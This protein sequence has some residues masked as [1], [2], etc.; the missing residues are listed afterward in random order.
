MKKCNSCGNVSND[1]VKFCAHCGSSSFSQLSENS[2]GQPQ[3]FQTPPPPYGSQPHDTTPPAYNNPPSYNNPPAY[4]NPPV[5]NPP[6]NSVN[7]AE[8]G[9]ENVI[10]GL[11]GALLFSLIGVVLYVVIYQ[12]N[13]IA[14]ICGL[15]MF[16]LASFG[17]GVFSKSK[18]KGSIPGL[19]ISIIVTIV[20]I[21]V[22]EYF[23]LAL[24]IYKVYS[25]FGVTIFDAIGATPDFLSSPEISEAVAHD[26]TYAYLFGF[27]ATIGSIINT[28][29][30]RKK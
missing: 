17:Y 28:A 4:N 2:G 27:I 5:Y 14:G 18:N 1:Q 20:M 22:A 11:V 19:I 24:E 13:I 3:S 30:L 9:S 29:R 6:V 7:P 12:F 23:C 15:V 21:F 25:D 26:L 10:A 8:K 16:V